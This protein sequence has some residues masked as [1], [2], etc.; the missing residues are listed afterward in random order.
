MLQTLSSFSPYKINGEEFGPLIF[1][2]QINKSSE[3]P[4]TWVL[5]EQ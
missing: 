1:S 3:S 2:Q 5:T 4:A